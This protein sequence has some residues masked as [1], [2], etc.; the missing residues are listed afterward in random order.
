VPKETAIPLNQ[1]RLTPV[2]WLI[3]IVA[4]IGFAFDTYEL[5]MLPLILPPALQEPGNIRLGSARFGLWRDLMF[6]VPAAA[7]GIFGL[8]GGYLTD[9]FGRRRVLT[10]SI[11]VYAFSALSAGFATSLPLLLL[12]R[13]TT[14][15]GICVE[16][17]AAVAWLAE[18]FPDPERRESVL[19][20]TQAFSS[21]GGLMVSGTYVLLEMA[22]PHLPAIHAGHAAWRYTLIS[23]VIPA[24]PLIVIRP[25]LP[26]SPMWLAK[27][28]A[29]M[30]KRP[31]FSELF[32]PALRST[33]LIT[34]LMFACGLGAAIGAIQ[35]L[36]QIV[37]GLPELRTLPVSRQQQIA[38]TVQLIQEIGGLAGRGALAALAL[39]LV[40]RRL[41]LRMFQVPGLVIV[42]LLFIFPATSS[43]SLLNWGVFLAGFLTIGQLSF[44]GNYLPRIYPTHLRGTG[45]SFAANIGGRMVGTAAALL[46]TQVVKLMPGG[47]P[48]TRLAY[49][50][51]AVAFMAYAAGLTLSWW[52]PEPKQAQLPE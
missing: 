29:G 12:F 47:S 25:F 48:T 46:T 28:S 27:K 49:A 30:L 39:I 22:G 9:R 2:Q 35:Q 50:A 6:Y 43:L 16:F 20:Y 11:F 42:P 23:G 51:A 33:T 14:F 21:F 8:V 38:G 44:W 17:V 3:C 26:E 13:C 36:P 37:P 40:R 5:M 31:N 45:E 15:I 7:G 34:A 32:T 52:L 24:L 4:V 18:L 41:L 19:G 10:W 1:T